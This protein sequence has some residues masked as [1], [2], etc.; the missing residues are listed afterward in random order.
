M[1]D[2][3]LLVLFVFFAFV[4]KT[5]AKTEVVC[6]GCL[7]L[8]QIT[9]QYKAMGLKGDFIPLQ[10]KASE[11]IKSMPDA[12][13]KLSEAQ[14]AKVVEVLRVAILPDPGRS[15]VQNNIDILDANLSAIRKAV[16]KIPKAEADEIITSIA[17]AAGENEDGNDP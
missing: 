1:K 10:L 13:N 3:I 2:I 5:M 4:A 16:K 12:K 7:E 14:V 11:I 17:V 8:S 6:K 15:I 9:E